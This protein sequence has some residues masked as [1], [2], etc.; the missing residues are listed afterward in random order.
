MIYFE[1]I[2]FGFLYLFLGGVFKLIFFGKLAIFVD[3]GPPP[4][5]VAV[6]WPMVL[7]ICVVW[8]L[9]KLLNKII[10]LPAYLLKSYNYHKTARVTKIFDIEEKTGLPRAHT[11][12][13]K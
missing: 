10:N 4:E 1:I 12:I 11:V 5:L 13:K 2:G 6:F 7:I 3:D 8:M 9:F